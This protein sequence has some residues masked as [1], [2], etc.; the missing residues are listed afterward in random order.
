MVIA[1]WCNAPQDS[2]HDAVNFAVEEKNSQRNDSIVEI[3]ID[4]KNALL[5]ALQSDTAEKTRITYLLKPSGEM[6]I[7]KATLDQLKKELLY[8]SQ[9]ISPQE[10]RI[11]I[12]ERFVDLDKLDAES[13]YFVQ[14]AI[15]KTLFDMWLV[16][17]NW[18]TV[19]ENSAFNGL[20]VITKQQEESLDMQ[21][22]KEVFW[23]NYDMQNVEVSYI[24]TPSSAVGQSVWSREW[25][26][27][28]ENI[29]LNEMLI[30]YSAIVNNR[31]IYPTT[32]EKYKKA[33]LHNEAVHAYLY[34]KYGEFSLT[35]AKNLGILEVNW[36]QVWYS[37]HHASEYLSD[38]SSI[39]IDFSYLSTALSWNFI[40]DVTRTQVAPQY[41][42]MQ[43][44]LMQ[45]M[46]VHDPIEFNRLMKIIEYY[47]QMYNH[48]SDPNKKY[49]IQNEGTMIFLQEFYKNLTPE[50][51]DKMKNILLDYAH[52]FV[53]Q[54]EDI[55]KEVK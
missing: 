36:Q 28:W 10:M 40:A 52:I 42:L 32:K 31:S 55:S 34:K 22:M 25:T 6:Q 54:F 30:E 15:A 13:S 1:N 20:Y 33:V 11:N 49:I 12:L 17:D 27:I 8:E 35:Y 2:D 45:V 23:N 18:T 26:T 21:V 16:M 46:R 7:D 29:I 9:N 14:T 47:R 37:P 48:E 50:K 53:K 43:I 19:W 3:T 39:L 24:W 38:V 5:P 4:I 44:V 51:I 41:I